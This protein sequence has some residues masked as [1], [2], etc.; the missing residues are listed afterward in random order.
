MATTNHV[1]A[2]VAA[3]PL[4]WVVP[5]ALY[6][7][8]FII[9]FD[10][11]RWH[12]PTLTAAL[13]LVA[14]YGT[15][16][17]NKEDVG[18]I[19]V[20]D[21]GMTGRCARLF[22][23]AI[24]GVTADATETASSAGPRFRVGFLPYL[25]FNYAAMFGICLLCH[26]ELVRRRPEVKYLTTFYL[27]IAAGGAVGGAAVTLLAP[28]L[29]TSYFEW[30]AAMFIASIGA[31]GLILHALVNRSVPAD[32]E[33][34]G[35]SAASSLAPRLIL[36][37]LLLPTALVL[38]DLVEYLH[39]PKKGVQFQ[40]R[41]FFGTLTVRERNPENPRTHNRV[42]LHGVTVHGS[43]FV[44][45]ERRGQPTTYYSTVSGVGRVLN[46]YRS[47]PP[48][49]GIRIGD[50]GLGTGTVA[51]YAGK[52]DSICF[53]EIDP[54]I[55]EIATSGRW[56]SYL[57]DCQ[58]RGAKCEIKLGDGRLTI[59]KEQKQRNLQL[60]HVLVLDAFSGDAV[61]VHLLTAEACDLYLARLAT[62]DADGEHGA[63]AVNISNRYLDLAR[64]VRAA[65][66]N[67]N[68]RA[69][70]IHSPQVPDQSFNSADWMILSRNEELLTALLPFAYEPAELEP[71]A[72]LWSDTRSS[73]FEVLK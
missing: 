66:A 22:V 57:A 29:F 3:V 11:P 47:Q 60:Y 8:T 37:L 20:Y 34:H 55:V 15:A 6:L 13:T 63:L 67:F 9:A 16:L 43:Q 44:A 64:V 23:E 73:L 70:H 61:P 65:A 33:L 14:V 68:I 38:L 46:Y 50:I 42:L 28:R 51:A 35:S 72:T 26:G 1:S 27:A 2:D 48:H 32:D 62:A 41:N 25:S 12:R 19:N 36:V 5:L 69:L 21:C 53:Y 18:W 40:G 52:G 54:A 30:T 58:D 59:Q 24:T 49:G 56:F 17:V 4:L 39:A 7:V 71:P 31:L 45:P 10:H